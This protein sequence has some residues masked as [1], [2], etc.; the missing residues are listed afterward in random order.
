[1]HGVFHMMHVYQQV[2]DMSTR[3]NS[4]N[5]M[6]T[7]KPGFEYIRTV[8]YA[9]DC[10]LSYFVY[11]PRDR[12]RHTFNSNQVNVYNRGCRCN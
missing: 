2:G 9:M 6:Q 4:T 5:I 11:I 8:V 7:L 3:T 1:M 12:L 10:K